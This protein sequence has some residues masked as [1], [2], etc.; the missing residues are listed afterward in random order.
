VVNAIRYYL[1]QNMWGAVA[2]GLRQHGIDVLKTQEAGNCGLSDTEQL[3]FAAA[4]G[5]VIVT[6]DVDYPAGTTH[7]GI[8]WCRLTK[9]NI[10][11]LIAVLVLV[12]A[13]YS[14]DE[15][16]NHIEYL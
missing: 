10:G 11:Q 16:L 2:I 15:M 1:D 7:A 5:R 9:H 13:V 12:H 14:E 8:A 4:S 6:F 3:S